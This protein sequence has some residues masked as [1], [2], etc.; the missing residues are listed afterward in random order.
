MRDILGA[1]DDPESEVTRALGRGDRSLA[2]D[3]LMT[4]YGRMVYRYCCRILGDSDLADDVLQT[5]FLQAFEAFERFD[6][7]SL[8]R[9]WLFG[10]AHHR[11]LDALKALRRRQHRL[12]DL[13]AAV[14][15][16]DPSVSVEESAAADERGRALV[17][18]LEELE[19]HIREAILLRYELGLSYPEI[20]AICNERAPTLQARVARSLPLLRRCLDLKGVA[21]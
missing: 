16:A 11:C 3:V 17:T 5:T 1:G 7:R 4:A 21:L 8:L 6:G 18:C 20:A 10:I 2:L 19:T 9:T 13:D 15:V 12:D 14:E